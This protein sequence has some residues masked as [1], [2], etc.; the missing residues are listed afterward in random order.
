MIAY[1]IEQSLEVPELDLTVV[2]TDDELIS[3]IAVQYDGTVIKRPPDIAGDE[4]PTELALID[5]LEQVKEKGWGEFDIIVVLEPT[6]PLREPTTISRCIR[7]LIN[8]EES[9]LLTVTETRKNY[10]QIINGNFLPLVPNQSRRRQEREP[11]YE[12][13]STVYVCRVS[14]LLNTGWLM[15]ENWRAEII[16]EREVIDINEASDLIVAESYLKEKRKNNEE[17]N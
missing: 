14:H 4:A 8:S 15:A 13:S 9:S 5:A 11:I 10:G 6:S 7:S 16:G 2:S 1:T 17:D 12:E 3:E